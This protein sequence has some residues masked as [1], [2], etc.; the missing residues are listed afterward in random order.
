MK[1]CKQ[2][3]PALVILINKLFYIFISVNITAFVCVSGFSLE[4]QVVWYP[5][6]LL[7]F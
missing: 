1:I 6:N 5:G 4:K 3:M 2:P 7:L